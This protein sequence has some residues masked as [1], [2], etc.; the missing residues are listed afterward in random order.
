MYSVD[1]SKLTED[2]IE[3]MK[4]SR[5]V[6]LTIMWLHNKGYKRYQL[7]D[8]GFSNEAIDEVMDMISWED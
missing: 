5:G 8:L 7:V 6:I 2:L 1:Y 4:K 3:E